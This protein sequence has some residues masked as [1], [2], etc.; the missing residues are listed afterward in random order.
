MID[1]VISKNKIV[2]FD[3]QKIILIDFWATWCVPC[4]P[5][6][7]QL[8]ILQQSR[9]KDVYIVSVSDENLDVITSYLPKHPIKID[10][11]KDCIDNSLINL[12]NVVSRPYAVLVAL[13]GR[14]LYQGH[15]AGITQE[16]IDKFAEQEK[17]KP[18]KKWNELFYEVKS[19]SV[20]PPPPINKSFQ[21]KRINTGENSMNI[22]RGVFNYSGPLSGLIK[23]LTDCS[24][25]QIVFN[26][27]NDFGVSMRCS[28]LELLN[29][30]AS[31][32][33]LIENN[34]PIKLESGNKTMEVLMLEVINQK[35]LWSN[36]Q[37][38]WGTEVNPI[39]LI[40]NDHIEADN[41]T[42]QKIAG[43]L[44]DIKGVPYYY[45]GNDYHLRDWNFHYRFDD[46][47]KEDL[48]ENFGIRIKKEKTNLPVFV[49]IRKVL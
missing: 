34:L 32:L 30:P 23:Y 42:L 26:G 8:E 10:V 41:I 19:V 18:A 13:D 12:F 47:M 49:I 6:T 46:L 11:F 45:K 38:D 22:D 21:I 1:R 24:S 44:S 48:E 33:S 35:K 3:K 5:A 27:I 36:S 29:S 17:S 9:P 7:Q 25:H 31:I 40:G 39:Y 4:V 14:I 37:I 16:M 2:D 28:E 15:P 20:K 43:L